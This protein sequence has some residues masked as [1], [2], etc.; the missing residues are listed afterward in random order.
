[1]ADTNESRANVWL[2]V[3]ANA[4]S[5]MSLSLVRRSG[6]LLFHPFASRFKGCRAKGSVIKTKQAPRMTHILTV[7]SG[8]S[9][10]QSSTFGA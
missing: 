8:A 5:E 1:M 10:K 3:R 7:T 4:D 2:L 6:M 9:R